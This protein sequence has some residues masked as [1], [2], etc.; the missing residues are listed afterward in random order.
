MLLLW[1]NTFALAIHSSGPNDDQTVAEVERRVFN[2]IEILNICLPGTNVLKHVSKERKLSCFIGK[3]LH[4]SMFLRSS[5]LGS[6]V[7][8]VKASVGLESVNCLLDIVSL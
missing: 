5:C 8:E 6:T 7:E 2:Y 4:M 1:L 3:N